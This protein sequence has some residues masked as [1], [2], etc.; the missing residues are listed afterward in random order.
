MAKYAID[1]STL[2]EIA[3]KFDQLKVMLDLIEDETEN[4]EERAYHLAT[5]GRELAHK[6]AHD[7][8]KLVPC[9]GVSHG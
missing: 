7:A 5:V 4:G 1:E 8:W 6:A 3:T 2:I 9:A